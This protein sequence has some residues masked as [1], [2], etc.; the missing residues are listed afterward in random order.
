MFGAAIDFGRH[1]T[2]FERCLD[3]LDGSRNEGLALKALFIELAGNFLVDIGMQEAEREVFEL[4]FQLPNPQA[5]GQ[6]GQEFE[7]F[8]CNAFTCRIRAMRVEAKRLGAR[9]Q[10][11]QYDAN[12][13]DHGQQHFAQNLDLYLKV[14]RVQRG[15]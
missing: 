8:P 15:I 3:A 1:T 9:G 7:C 14:M 12:I 4:P 10:P 5:I 11:K 2:L 6:G 13:L